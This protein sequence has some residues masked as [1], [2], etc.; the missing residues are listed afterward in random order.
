VKPTKVNRGPATG[1]EKSVQLAKSGQIDA[2]LDAL[3]DYFCEV[4]AANQFARANKI[5]VE[6][7]VA[8]HSSEFLIGVLTIS[9]PSGIQFLVGTPEQTARA[10]LP[11]RKD[12][13]KRVEAIIKERQQWTPTVLKG[14]ET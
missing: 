10:G 3:Y 5:L 2:A 9:R 7:D 13:F 12:F 14:L 4:F 6:M 1:F 11:A 8:A